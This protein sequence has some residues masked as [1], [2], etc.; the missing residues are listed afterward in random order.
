MVLVANHNQYIIKKFINLG[1]FN[2]VP[3]SF[4]IAAAYRSGV[5]SIEMQSSYCGNTTGISNSS[6]I[7]FN[8]WQ[9]QYPK[10]T[11]LLYDGLP[12]LTAR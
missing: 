5:R 4:F 11:T 10:K 1:I 3:T 9:N 8:D 12:H 2:Q 6:S 7:P